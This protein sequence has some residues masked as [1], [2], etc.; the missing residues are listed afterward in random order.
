MRCSIGS[1]P[2]SYCAIEPPCRD[3]DADRLRR[4]HRRAAAERDEPVAARRPDTR[5]RA[6]S[7]SAMSGL[8]R[9]SS[10]TTAP[11]SCGST[12]STSPAAATP[13]SVTSI[14]RETPSSPSTSRRLDTAPG[15]CTRRVGTLTARTMST[16]TG[17][18]SPLSDVRVR[19]RRLLALDPLAEL[20]VHRVVDRRRLVLGERR[21]QIAF[22][23]CRGVL[24]ALALPLLEARVVGDRA[25]G[26]TPSRSWRACAGDRGSASRARSSGTRPAPGRSRTCRRPARTRATCRAGRRRARTSRSPS[27]GRPRASRRR[28]GRS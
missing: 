4:V 5:R 3:D 10:K 25:S 23:R 2:H 22:A 11:S 16:S 27:P 18:R 24:R 15:P 19:E 8:G 21:F 14:G 9:T 20:L 1:R 12:R 7:T 28:G 26:R 17:M 13:G 6:R